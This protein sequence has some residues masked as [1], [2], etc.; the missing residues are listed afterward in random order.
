MTPDNQRMKSGQEQ[1]VPGGRFHAWVLSQLPTPPAR[2]LEV[3]C[4]NGRLARALNRAGYDVVAVDPRAPNGRIFRRCRVEDLEEALRFDVAVAGLALHHVESLSVALD[5]VSNL[6]RARGRIVVYEF[7]WDQFDKKTA[8]SFWMRRAALSPRM[9]RHFGGRSP[10]VSL[11]KWRQTFRG[12]HTY[13]QMR[14]ELD[15]RFIERLFAWTPYLHEYPGGIFSEPLERRLI[16][17]GAIRPLGFRY[18]GR[19]RQ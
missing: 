15:R 14:R 9:R 7:A 18:V 12:L 1:V 11:N 17:A 16:E 3:G 5:K 6:L 8:L 13:R 4:G 10:A 2:I 19:L